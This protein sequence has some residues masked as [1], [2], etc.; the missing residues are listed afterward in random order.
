MGTTRKILF[1]LNPVSGVNNKKIVEQSIR[2]VAEQNSNTL[3]EIKYTE[4]QNHGTT[5]SAE[6]VAAGFDTVVAVG[7][8]GSINEVAKGLLNSDAALGLIPMGSGNGLANHLSIPF[9]IEKA[10]KIILQNKQKKI[11]TVN[12]NDDV[13]FSIAGI[14]FD[15]LV[16]R[17]Y[18]RIKRR[19]FW[20]YF[21]IVAREYPL[22]EPDFY[23]VEVN[24]E[25]ITTEALF[26]TFANSN[27]FGYNVQVAPQAE[28]DDGL[29]DVCIFNKIPIIK[30]PFLAHLLFLKRIEELKYVQIIKAKNLK[31]RR[32]RESWVNLD[33][34]PV[35]LGK[36]LSIH[37]NPRSL[38]VITP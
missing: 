37:V 32:K 28:L 18:A 12:I 23:E 8:D 33:G 4:Y 22:Y 10:L 17:K 36:E 35:R 38:N 34:D 21:E 19:G 9:N 31:V 25:Q 16:A 3:I 27:Q 26:I 29:A 2:K 15:A 30:I 6:A 5:L 14:G 1:I 11:D 7:G 20:P 13:F 24:G